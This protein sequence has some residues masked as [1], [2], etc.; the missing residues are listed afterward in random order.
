MKITTN[1]QASLFN[2]RL[3]GRVVF[4]LIIMCLALLASA[5]QGNAQV[6]YGVSARR[7]TV[8]RSSTAVVHGTTVVTAQASAAVIP[9]GY[10]AVLPA[11]Y[12]VVG[13]GIYLANAV[14]YR[15]LFHR[16]RTA[17]ARI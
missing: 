12:R 11:G 5:A 13:G 8:V 7:T 4:G 9:P 3:L 2:S 6:V 10:I 17:Y 16:G 1:N 14:R 15:S